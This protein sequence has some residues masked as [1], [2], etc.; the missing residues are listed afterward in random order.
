M[1]QVAVL[2]IS[3]SLARGERDVDESGRLVA[4]ILQSV[5]LD[6]TERRSV[7]DDHDAIAS[8]LIRLRDKGAALIITTGGTGFGPRDLTPEATQSV[9]DRPAPGLAEAMRAEGLAKTPLASL[10]RSVTGISANTLIV[11]LPGSPKG[12]RE[13]LE[14]IVEVLPHALRLLGGHTEHHE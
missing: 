7:P 5:G 12:V 9:I 4:E 3:D 11:N 6:P 13:S 1:T 2:T 10:S 14:A 8:E